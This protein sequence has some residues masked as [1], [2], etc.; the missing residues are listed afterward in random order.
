MGGFFLWFTTLNHTTPHHTALDRTTPHY[1]KLPQRPHRPHRQQ[2]PHRPS[3][4]MSTT[5]MKTH[6]SPTLL[7]TPRQ[8][9]QRGFE[10]CSGLQPTNDMKQCDINLFK[11]HYGSDPTVL[12]QVWYDIVTA[13]CKRRRRSL[14][15]FPKT[16]V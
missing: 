8:V 6:I 4:T 11:A 13:S 14:P 9:L 1:K 2:Q 15:G 5:T 7:L 16:L 12:S 3:T 10:V